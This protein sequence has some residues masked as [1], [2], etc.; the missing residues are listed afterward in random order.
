MIISYLNKKRIMSKQ[1][2][3]LL[4]GLE[5]VFKPYKNK[6]AQAAQT[7]VEQDISKY[8]IFVAAKQTV[9]LG[10]P[11]I[12]PGEIREGWAINASTLEEF[13]AKQ[14]ILTEKVDDFRDLY[15]KHSGDLCIFVFDEN[16]A[17]FIFIPAA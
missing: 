12:P 11:L 16:N 6:M 3:Y 7:I 4:V 1:N 13:Y 10:I 8:P 9:E 17:N 5:K 14:L 15:K 2:G